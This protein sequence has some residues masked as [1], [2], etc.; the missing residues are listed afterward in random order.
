M[1]KRLLIVARDYNTAQHWAKDKRL[2]P[3]RWLYVSAFYNIQGN[4]ESPYVLL[5][6]WKTRPDADIINENLK[7]HKCFIDERFIS[8]EV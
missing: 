6:N 1:E 4:P 3:G 2:S 7:L 8:P 5:D